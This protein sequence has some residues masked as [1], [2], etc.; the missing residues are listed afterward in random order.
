MEIRKEG[1]SG[2]GDLVASREEI[3]R[4]RAAAWGPPYEVGCWERLI[5]GKI[6][7]EICS[8]LFVSPILRAASVKGTHVFIPHQRDG[9]VPA[10]DVPMSSA[11]I[12]ERVCR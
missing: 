10:I 11:G 7:T 1:E 5:G 2:L 3:H 12:S 6:P 8:K 9:G 4:A